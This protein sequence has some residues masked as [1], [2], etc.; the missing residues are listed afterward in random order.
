MPTRAMDS[1]P[2]ADANTLRRV[3]SLLRDGYKWIVDADIQSYYDTIDHGRLMADVAKEVA[4]AAKGRVLG[5]LEALL[6]QPVMEASSKWQPEEGIPQGS[7]IGPLMAN[8]YLHP[9]DGAMK[10]ETWEVTR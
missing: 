1:D 2:D 10:S 9:V 7:T 8:I 4:D 3:E 6:E 5:L